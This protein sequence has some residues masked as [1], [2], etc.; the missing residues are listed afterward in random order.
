MRRRTT[1]VVTAAVAL[2][3]AT[4]AYAATVLNTR[5]LDQARSDAARAEARAS[6]RESTLR[7]FED[8][9]E[10]QLAQM[11]AP[12][13]SGPVKS[14]V[15]LARISPAEPGTTNFVSLAV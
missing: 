14:G 7:T 4:G 15:Y 11:R 6:E 9:W 1:I 13:P 2:A 8:G 12:E 3:L 10:A 5:A